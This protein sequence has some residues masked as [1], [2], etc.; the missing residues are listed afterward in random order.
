MTRKKRA[1]IVDV[2]LLAGVSRQTVSRVLNKSEN[3]SE[4][5]REKVVRAIKELNYM[6][7]PLARNLVTRRTHIIGVITMD[8]RSMHSQI[9]EGAE[10]YARSNGYQL[11]I[12]GCEHEVTGEPLHSPLLARQRIEGVLIVYQGSY[13]DSF[14][15][16]DLLPDDIPIVTTG[17]AEGKTNVIPVRIEN[18]KSSEKAVGHLIE[19]GHRNIAQIIGPPTNFDSK[20]RSQGY[21]DALRKA[22]IP[23]NE[24][25][26][27]W[28]D[29]QI[30]S[31]Y[32][33]ALE[34]LER[35]VHFTAVF[36]HS[37][38]MAIGCMRALKDRGIKVPQDVAVI[39]F[40]DNDPARFI[41]PPLTT[42]KYPG[43]ELGRV[44][45]QTLIDCIRG[46]RDFTRKNTIQ[47]LEAELLIRNSCGSRGYSAFSEDD[48]PKA[49]GRFG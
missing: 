41:E 39:G 16:L 17:Y 32:Q 36:A 8:F 18:R 21:K 13:D 35:K 2:A 6:P 11:F 15:F 4:E 5:A 43:Y 19:L 1:T 28:G 20:Y 29:W 46:N 27:V 48:F 45:V 9:L 37:D 22:N 7:D 31:G 34:L 44:C 14:Q 23:F 24:E 30:N 10:I 3:V 26:S 49:R 12:S 47:P 42:I 33:A 40:N 38:W 25:L